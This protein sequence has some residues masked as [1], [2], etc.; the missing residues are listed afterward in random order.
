MPGTTTQLELGFEPIIR[1]VT[2]RA[3][4]SRLSVSQ[5]PWPDPDVAQMRYCVSLRAAC[6]PAEVWLPFSSSVRFPVP[7]DWL[8]T[9]SLWVTAE[10]RDSGGNPILG[11]DENQNS[12]PRARANVRLSSSVNLNTPADLQPPAV[13]TLLAPTRL[14]SPVQGSVTI[15]DGRCCVGGK[16]GSS[17]EIPVTFRAE[18]RAG[19]VTEMRVA[20]TCPNEGQ[21]L[22]SDWEPF[23]A[24]KTYT[25]TAA[26]NWVGWYIAVQYRDAG[27][28]VSGVYCDDVS[29]EGMP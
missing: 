6:A 24:E 29:V 25:T 3:D 20:N 21:G 10:F 28:N 23:V 7:V 12:A 18:S 15:A 1:S 8:G 14:A 19:P 13:Q 9:R 4:G 2:L 5:E 16:A 26:L 11:I 22:K 27:G 17:V